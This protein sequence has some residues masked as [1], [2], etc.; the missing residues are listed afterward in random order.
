MASDFDLLGDPIPEGW[1]RRGRPAHIPTQENRCKVMLLLAQGR[2][3]DRIAAALGITAKTLRK[4]YSRELRDRDEARARV[5]GALVMML[6][7]S[8]Q[9]GN[10]AAMK[11]LGR[12]YEK[13]DRAQL[14][15]AYHEARGEDERVGK[16]EARLRESATAGAGTDWGDDLKAGLERPN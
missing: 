1:G 14:L 16:K 6:W 2:P 3:S 10:V 4:H 8:A 5:D 7:R 12:L 13:I 11:E 9:D 15:D